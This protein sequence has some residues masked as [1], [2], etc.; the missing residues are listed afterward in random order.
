LEFKESGL[1]LGLMSG[2]SLDG[3]DIAACR[4]K[5]TGSGK[6]QFEIVAASSIPYD[7]NLRSALEQAF[8]LSPKELEGLSYSYGAFIAEQIKDFCKNHEILP[9]L[10][11]SHGHTVHHRPSDK[12][13]LQIGDGRTI[14]EITGIPTVCNFR[15]Q[16]VLKGGQGAPLVPIGDEL[17]FSAFDYCLNLGGFAN[18]SWKSEDRRL[19]CDI[20]PCNMVLNKLANRMNFP[21]DDHGNLA[22]AGMVQD[23]LLDEW[24]Q[25]EYYH[26]PFPK[27]LGREWFL[28]SF[29]PIWNNYPLDIKDLLRTATEHIS[30]QLA[31]F[32][33]KIETGT[34]AKILLTG[35]GAYNDFLIKRLSQK[36]PGHFE[37]VVPSGVIIDF[38][39]ALIFGLLGYLRKLGMVNTLSS[40]T[41]AYEDHCSGEYFP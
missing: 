32:I 35:G 28:E 38:K 16:D 31:N 26:L 23:Q 37:L 39:E 3:L 27:S 14:R 34:K 33:R 41:G 29:E 1:I 36:L 30:D 21:Y 20:V 24:N 25:L 17:L 11:S 22:S 15:I 5:S 12:V 8:Y 9:D 6:L 40:V 10:I 13:S 2:T 18:I 19:A 7:Q 4:F